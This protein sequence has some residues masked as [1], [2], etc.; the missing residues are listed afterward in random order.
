MKKNKY[1]QFLEDN[2]WKVL[3][4]KEFHGSLEF[5]YTECLKKE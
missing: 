3:N 1:L 5:I 2:G 4:Q